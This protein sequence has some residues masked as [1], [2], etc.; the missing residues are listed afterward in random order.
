MLR[1][2]AASTEK[3]GEKS[4]EEP[5]SLEILTVEKSST[6]AKSMP[7]KLFVVPASSKITKAAQDRVALKGKQRINISSDSS[8]KDTATDN[9]YVEVR[10]PPV[11]KIVLTSHQENFGIYP[12]D[13]ITKEDRA[14]FSAF[15]TNNPDHGY[16]N[17]KYLH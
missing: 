3:V 9:G 15:K 13:N 6:D 11:P 1:L 16:N 12:L 17:I 10:L 8:D 5:P 2:P 4:F 7:N 14:I